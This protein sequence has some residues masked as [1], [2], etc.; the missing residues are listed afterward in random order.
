M[1]KRPTKAPNDS[2][3]GAVSAQKTFPAGAGMTQ[4]GDIVFFE[5]NTSLKKK[6]KTD[7]GTPIREWFV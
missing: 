4:P 3:A 6:K 7:K 5:E 1:M 2:L